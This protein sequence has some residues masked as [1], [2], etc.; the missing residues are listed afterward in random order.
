M[1]FF[2]LSESTVPEIH[3]RSETASKVSHTIQALVGVVA[4]TH[5]VTKDIQH[6]HHLAENQDAVTVHAETSQQFIKQDHLATAHNEPLQGL[7]NV[8]SAELCAV[9]EKWMIGRLFQLNS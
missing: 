9:K 1:A 4:Q 2:L 8:V 5:I 6:S 3:I 7:L